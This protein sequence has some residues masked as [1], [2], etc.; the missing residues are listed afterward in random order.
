MSSKGRLEDLTTV[1]YMV[2][3]LVSG[4]YGL[5]LWV[6]QGISSMLPNAVYLDITRSPYVFILGSLSVM[7]GLVVEMNGT[8]LPGRKAKL[9]SLANTLLGIAGASLF[10][11]VLGALYASGL[12]LGT[13]ASDFIVGRYDLVFPVVMVVLSIL[14]SAQFRW[15]AL[16]DRKVLAVIALLLVFP[17]IYEIG[18]RQVTLGLGLA[19]AFL[20]LGMAAY[21]LPARKHPAA[22]QEES[23]EEE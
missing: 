16:G 22:E 14:L 13:T 18:K 3:F 7:V 4:L 8:P 12:H 5:F 6:R 11:A 9:A 21:L 15:S 10:F 1:L 17:S 20:V 23:E 19:L 2:P